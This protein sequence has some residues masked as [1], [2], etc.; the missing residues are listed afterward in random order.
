MAEQD[1]LGASE[2]PLQVVVDQQERRDKIRHCPLLPRFD[3]LLVQIYLSS[4]M[5]VTER[6]EPK[7]RNPM[8]RVLVGLLL[9]CLLLLLA[10]EPVHGGKDNLRQ[11]CEVVA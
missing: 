3:M 1:V 4:S 9:L 2:A 5:R 6:V 8:A 10:A 11:V 7:F